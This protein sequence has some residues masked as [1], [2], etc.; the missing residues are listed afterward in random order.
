MGELLGQLLNS[1][2]PLVLSLIATWQK[3]HDTTRL[4]TLDELRA[5]YLAEIDSYLA[6]GAAWRATHPNA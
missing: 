1:F 2:A 3:D 6:E 4:P 5:D